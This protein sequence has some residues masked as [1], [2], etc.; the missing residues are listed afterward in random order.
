MFIVFTGNGKGKTTAA[1]GQAMRAAGDG[2]KALMVQFI[3]G[4]WKSGEDESHKKFGP[5]FRIVK[6]GLGFVGIGGDTL[7]R[8]EHARAARE[9][10]DYALSAV[11][12]GGLDMIILDEV[13]NA[14]DLGLIAEAEV[15]SFLEYARPRVSTIIF[16]GRN[17]PQVFLD[18]ADL[19][20]EMR[21]V[22]HPFAAGVKGKKGVEY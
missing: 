13:A 22:K 12:Q 1:L 5:D 3:K 20:T 21:E 9:A 8:A 17:C 7:P 19:V 11:T 16:T 15:T 4:P 2:Q 14:I 6:K 10:L 18:A